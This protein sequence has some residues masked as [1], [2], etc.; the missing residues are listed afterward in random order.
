L[1]GGRFYLVGAIIGALFIQTLTTTLYARN[2]SAD[3]S[4]VPKALVIVL[5]FL[6]QSEK[7]KPLFKRL[8]SSFPQ[9][10]PVKE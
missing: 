1:R 6:L 9:L 5:V 8:T 3:I 2:I 10:K 4:P 7:M